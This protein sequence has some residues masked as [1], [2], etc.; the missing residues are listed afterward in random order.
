MLEFRIGERVRFQ[1]DRREIVGTLVR[2]NKKSVT[3]VTD[4]GER[5]TVSPGLLHPITTSGSGAEVITIDAEPRSGAQ[6]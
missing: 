4:Q 5:W 6:K 2:Y 1:T 3:V